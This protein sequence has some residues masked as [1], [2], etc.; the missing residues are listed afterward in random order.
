METDRLVRF[1]IRKMTEHEVAA[2][3]LEEA[4]EIVIFGS[5]S[6][7]LEKSNSDLDV[8]CIGKKSQKLKTRFLDLTVMPLEETFQAK[9]L[10]NELASHIAKYG[11]WIK[12][13]PK[14]VDSVQIGAEA[15]DAKR[16]RIAAFLRALPSRWDNLDEIFRQKYAT[17]LRRETQR[18]LLL[19]RGV[20]VPPTR[21]LDESWDVFTIPEQEIE[22]SLVGTMGSDEIRFRRDL[23]DRI[24]AALA[25]QT[26][27]PSPLQTLR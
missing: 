20:A 16:R 6:V 25:H 13:D 12:G 7:G 24:T 26:T 23:L 17:K 4:D 22:R 18:L 11:T 3:C 21:I 5:R 10:G 8:L 27:I 1:A 19:E 14:W 9:W 15:V 2:E